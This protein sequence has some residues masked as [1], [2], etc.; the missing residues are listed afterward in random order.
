MCE[1]WPQDAVNL[2]GMNPKTEV[3]INAKVWHAVGTKIEE[4]YA[5]GVY[6]RV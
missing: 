5:G 4:A 1:N 6:G 2:S 3:T